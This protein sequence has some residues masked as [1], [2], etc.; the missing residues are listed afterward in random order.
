M[1][2]TKI[3]FNLEG[4]EAVK[5]AIGGKMHVKVGVLQSDNARE[6]GEYGNADI[7]LVHEL[8]SESANIPPRSFLRMPLETKRALIVKAASGAKA[9]AA[10][11]AKDYKRLFG[12]IGAAAQ[13]IIWDAFKTGGFGSWPD[14]SDATKQA[15][16]S[17]KILVD[18]SQLERS[19]TYEVVSK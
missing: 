15:K 7:G 14:I 16:G 9:T 11:E 3:K 5:N 10:I 4:L 13:G 1:K 12:L 2:Q 8:G 17:S 19:I 18:T 6:E